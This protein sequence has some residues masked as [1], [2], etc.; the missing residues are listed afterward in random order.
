MWH[1]CADDH[2]QSVDIWLI[3][4]AL[5]SYSAISKWPISA[6]VLP[7]WRDAS[8]YCQRYNQSILCCTLCLIWKLHDVFDKTPIYGRLSLQFGLSYKRWN[9]SWPSLSI[10]WCKCK[11]VMLA[12]YVTELL[13]SLPPPPIPTPLRCTR[14]LLTQTLSHTFSIA[15]KA[16]VTL[17]YFLRGSFIYLWQRQKVDWWCEA[18]GGGDNLLGHHSHMDSSNQHPFF[19]FGLYMHTRVISNVPFTFSQSSKSIT[20]ADNI[21]R[22]PITFSTI[23]WQLL[24]SSPLTSSSSS[25]LVSKKSSM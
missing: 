14:I 20:I 12:N 24:E 10:F 13:S 19:L 8:Q 25:C 2:R 4:N 7:Y 15:E 18:N 16:E 3:W 22:W 23:I 5:W 21:W 9:R 6:A 17:E 11:K 1:R